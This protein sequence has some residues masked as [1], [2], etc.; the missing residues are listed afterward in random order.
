MFELLNKI[1]EKQN[2]VCGT[3]CE[4]FIRNSHCLP[5]PPWGGVFAFPHV[6]P[7]LVTIIS[8]FLYSL[9]YLIV[10]SVFWFPFSLLSV[11]IVPY[12]LLPY[13]LPASTLSSFPP[14]P[15]NPEGSLGKVLAPDPGSGHAFSCVILGRVQILELGCAVGRVTLFFFV[16]SEITNEKTS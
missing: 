7:Q 9:G 12:C 8:P 13:V 2:H 5:H 4:L 3:V 6:T 1:C 11:G 15:P 10:L 14:V 16:S